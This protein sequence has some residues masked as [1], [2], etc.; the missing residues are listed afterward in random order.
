MASSL[1]E[2]PAKAVLLDTDVIVNWLIKEEESVSQRPLWKTPHRIIS[3]IE[4]ATLRGFISLTTL[5]EIRYLLRRKKSCSQHEIGAFISDITSI[6]DVI[7]PDEIS[8]LEANKLQMIY[9][10]DPFDSI[11]LGIA[12]ILKPMALISRDS[13]FLKIASRHVAALTPEAF[14]AIHIKR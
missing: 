6:F 14:E 1:I 4:R 10:L 9:P 12:V 11:I 3:L 7:I 8:L 13:E 5:F 2:S